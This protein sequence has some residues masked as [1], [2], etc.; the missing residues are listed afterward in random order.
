MHPFGRVAPREARAGHLFQPRPRFRRATVPQEAR[1]QGPGRPATRSAKPTPK[2]PLTPRRGAVRCAAHLL[3]RT[4]NAAPT[5]PETQPIATPYL[6]LTARRAIR[7]YT[8]L[9]F[10]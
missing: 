5:Y 8:G 10:S 6:P 7:E 3:P 4:R 1:R 9:R 2:A